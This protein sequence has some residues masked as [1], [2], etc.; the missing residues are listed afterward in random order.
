MLRQHTPLILPE[1][2][3]AVHSST[4]DATTRYVV[5][6]VIKTHPAGYQYDNTIISA[7][8]ARAE[9]E[10]ED[11]QAGWVSMYKQSD[12]AAA[13]AH[14]VV[15]AIAGMEERTRESVHNKM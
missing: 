12:L 6:P 5:E 3:L 9:M 10:R 11:V 7:C 1:V 2:F 15:L 8:L 4:P 13:Y 14:R